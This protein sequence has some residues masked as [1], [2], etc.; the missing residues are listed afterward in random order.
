MIRK[1][2]LIHHKNKQNIQGFMD[3]QISDLNTLVNYSIDIMYCSVLNKVEK[4]KTNQYIDLMSEK[5]RH[6]GQIVIV[7]TNI[8]KICAAY[9]SNILSDETFFE[10]IRDTSESLDPEQIAK[11]LTSK[12][13]FDLINT[14]HANYT[15]CITLQRKKHD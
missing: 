12:H 15:T 4:N 6:G 1:I 11:Y 10:M 8:K 7:V 9:V 5:I 2:N 13:N 14:E 3:V